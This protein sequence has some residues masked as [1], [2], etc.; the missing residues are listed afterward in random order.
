M[1][2]MMATPFDKIDLIFETFNDYHDLNSLL[3]TRRF[4]KFSRL[5]LNNIR[6]HNLDW[7]HKNTFSG[8]FLSFY[9]SHPLCH[10]IGMIYGLTDRAFLLSHP[11]FHQKNIEFVIELLLENGYPLNLMFEKINSRLKTL[12]YNN[13]NPTSRNNLDKNKNSSDDINK[14]IIVLSYINKISESIATT[15]DKSKYITG[16]RILNNLGKFVK[17]HKDTNE[18]LTNNNV[19]YKISCKD[20]NASYVDQ[21]KRQLKIRI[22]EHKNNSK[23]LSS[24]PSVITEHILEYSHSFDWEN[25]KILDIESN[26]YKRAVSEML[27]IKE[28]SNSINAQKDMELLD[29]AYFHVLD[30]LSKI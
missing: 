5:T 25:I 14:K 29:N 16:Y 1:W 12:I 22:K 4:F 15:I 24:K 13:R 21:T 27:H 28:Q 17:V 19:I 18:L 8:R 10:K 9:S 2:I 26:Y 30:M 6:E 23:S 20:C 11:S 3:N 7:F